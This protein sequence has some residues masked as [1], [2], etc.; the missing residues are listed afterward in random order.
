MENINKTPAT[1]ES[2]LKHQKIPAPNKRFNFVEI[3][4]L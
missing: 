2:V 4:A 1:P 3:A